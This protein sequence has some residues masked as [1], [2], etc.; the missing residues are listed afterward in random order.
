MDGAVDEAALEM[1]EGHLA[2]CAECRAELAAL[3]A[4]TGT[5]RNVEEIESPAD[6]KFSIRDAIDRAT[7]APSAD[8]ERI[9]VL[10]SNYL[11]RELANEQLA[12]VSEHLESCRICEAEL[13]LMRKTVRLVG[14]IDTVEP[15]GGLRS[16]I[17]A[18]TVETPSS[19]QRLAGVAAQ[20]LRP[21]GMRWA[22]S[23]AL[24]LALVLMFALPDKQTPVRKVAKTP[25]VETPRLSIKPVAT[26]SPS[27]AK[28]D[29]EKTTLAAANGDQ[30]RR[31]SHRR[32]L[33]N[34][35]TTKSAAHV[36]GSVA[37]VKTSA[38][39]TA[40]E[41]VASS[42][43]TTNMPANSDGSEAAKSSE[44]SE[45]V[46]KASADNKKEAGEGTSAKPAPVKVAGQGIFTAE[47][48]AAMIQNIKRQMKMKNRDGGVS[49]SLFDVKF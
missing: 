46:A 27:I 45:E 9:E 48:D 42:V 20:I 29:V 14:S 10:L 23:A 41:A 39:N 31:R 26:E 38:K 2:D 19:A 5:I 35:R 15:P 30:S 32:I 12:V 8:C 22:A 47:D 1:I 24:A 4:I 7:K 28:V 49:V 33:T 25:V 36:P 17:I 37:A 6:L 11:D 18:A 44:I 34:P 3:E 40:P 13:A 16:R 43:V 21:V